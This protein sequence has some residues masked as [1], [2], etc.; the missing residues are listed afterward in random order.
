MP[1]L[2]DV[3]FSRQSLEVS[4]QA[5]TVHA[6]FVRCA[7]WVHA[8]VWCIRSGW[9]TVIYSNLQWFTVTLNQSWIVWIATMVRCEVFLK[10]SG[11]L[12]ALAL[13]H[14]RSELPS[15]NALFSCLVDLGLT[16]HE[17]EK[18]HY[19]SWIPRFSIWIWCSM[20]VS[21]QDWGKHYVHPWNQWKSLAFLII[22]C[23]DYWCHVVGCHLQ[24]PT[25]EA[26]PW[27]RS[28][29]FRTVPGWFRDCSTYG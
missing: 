3:L 21:S 18:L 13:G 24:Y 14:E 25:A 16:G 8:Q 10:W 11:C 5:Q 17:I 20:E 26:P 29:R 23:Q 1:L 9:F 2:L 19:L 4:P 6:A 22:N 27:R 28:R 12:G 15:E 7:G